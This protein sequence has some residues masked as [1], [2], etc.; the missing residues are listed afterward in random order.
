MRELI[1]TLKKKKRKKSAGGELIIE[2][3]PRILASEETTATATTTI[4]T[5]QYII[6]HNTSM[7]LCKSLRILINY[8][9]VE[10]FALILVVQTSL[11]C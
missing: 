1:S 6:L 5:W 7:A 9:N 10:E 11:C 3:S 8:G 2:S 4:I